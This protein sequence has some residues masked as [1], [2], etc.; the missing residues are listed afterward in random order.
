MNVISLATLKE[1]KNVTSAI[2]TMSSDKTKQSIGLKFNH[3][4]KRAEYMSS[5][6]DDASLVWLTNKTREKLGITP[7]NIIKKLQDGVIAV[8]ETQDKDGKNCTIL[9]SPGL[10]SKGEFEL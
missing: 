3:D 10:I 8:V 6:K 4:V 1:L 7:E 2:V 5:E 9:T